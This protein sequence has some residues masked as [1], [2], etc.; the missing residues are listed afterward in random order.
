MSSLFPSESSG[1]ALP[2][3]KFIN[4]LVLFYRLLVHQFCLH[5]FANSMEY[6]PEKGK[7]KGIALKGTRY[8]SIFRHEIDI[9][10]LYS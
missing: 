7:G 10:V 3:C 5:Y 4:K 8:N 6:N 2:I 1:E 9:P